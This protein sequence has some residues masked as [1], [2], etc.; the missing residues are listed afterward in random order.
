MSLETTLQEN[1][2]ALNKHTEVLTALLQRLTSG[3]VNP[4][5]QATSAPETAPAPEAKK[6][7]DAVATTAPAAAST[8]APAAAVEPVTYD[9]VKQLV[10]DLGAANKRT[11]LV[12]LLQRFGVQ[13]ASGLAPD[14]YADFHAEALKIKG[15]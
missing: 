8:T 11:E 4:E 5:T 15:Q 6:Q 3:F 7:P 13:K 14:Q 9:Q 2:I 1:T 12:D 10:L